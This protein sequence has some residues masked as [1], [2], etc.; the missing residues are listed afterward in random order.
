MDRPR[1]PHPRLGRRLRP[2]APTP[3]SV[4]PA[5]AHGGTRALVP[6]C[7]G[8]GPRLEETGAGER[9]TSEDLH[10]LEGLGGGSHAH[11]EAGSEVMTSL[12]SPQG[13]G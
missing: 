3:P 11:N 10:S 4:S 1:H 8:G 7:W 6:T 13:A 2:E 9:L 12:V 5:L